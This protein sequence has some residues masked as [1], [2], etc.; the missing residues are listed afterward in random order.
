[1]GTS[2]DFHFNASRYHLFR[3]LKRACTELSLKKLPPQNNIFTETY[4]YMYRAKNIFLVTV[5][6]L[7]KI[8][9]PLFPSN[10]DSAKLSVHFDLQVSEP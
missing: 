1:M 5:K 7:Q 8:Y 10:G 9:C 2:L 4:M 6:T 3:G